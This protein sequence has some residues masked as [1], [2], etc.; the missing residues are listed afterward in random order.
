MKQNLSRFLLT[1]LAPLLLI[2]L[3]SCQNQLTDVAE[4]APFAKRDKGKPPPAVPV[5][6]EEYWI[7]P[8][9]GVT[10]GSLIHVAGTGNVEV[11]SLNLCKRNTIC[12]V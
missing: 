4:D 1:V 9:P 2:G 10:G 3:A 12:S 5:V 7:F 6:L 8:D 11:V